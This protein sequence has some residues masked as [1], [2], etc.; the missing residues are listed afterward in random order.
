[1]SFLGV[2]FGLLGLV[3]SLLA[4]L[5][6]MIGG[7]PAA[8]LGLLAVL[9]GFL[10]RRKS[11]KGIPAIIIGIITVAAAVILT[12]SGINSARY[13]FEKIKED[14]SDMPVIA[15]YIDKVRPE[16]GFLGFLTVTK[17][18]EEV[19]QIGE[20]V[21]YLIE[22]RGTEE[23]IEMTLTVHNRTG[24]KADLTVTDKNRPA[25][26]AEMKDIPDGSDSPFVCTAV[27]RGGYPALQVSFTTESRWGADTFLADKNTNDIT[28]LKKENIG[29]IDFSAPAE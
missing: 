24:E 17:D 11:K 3:S 14:P 25:A 18:A 6:G 8:F 13:H 10:A 5:T 15:R 12:I 19:K 16:F 28:L 26:R 22:S 27:L 23:K 9:F 7:I 20:E 2:I 21:K 1:M 4:P 29:G